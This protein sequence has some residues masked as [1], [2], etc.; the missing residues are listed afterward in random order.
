MEAVANTKNWRRIVGQRVRRL[1][2]EQARAAL[3]AISAEGIT[4][5]HPTIRALTGGLNSQ[6]INGY[7]QRKLAARA[8]IIAKAAA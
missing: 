5:H 8:G 4:I 2:P 3:N 6:S 7:V 1:T